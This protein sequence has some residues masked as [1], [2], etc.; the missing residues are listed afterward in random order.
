MN[1]NTDKGLPVTG[2]EG[3]EQEQKYSSTVSWT[4]ALDGD[5]RLTS[6]QFTHV[7]IWTSIQ[8]AIVKFEVKKA[9]GISTTL[10]QI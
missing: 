5:G 4:L 1:A 9:A 2:H 3:P 7:K 6:H 10:L 8:I